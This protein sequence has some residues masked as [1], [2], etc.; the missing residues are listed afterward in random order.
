M[1]RLPDS[2][3]YYSHSHSR[4]RTHRPSSTPPYTQTQTPDSHRYDTSAHTYGPT[5]DTLSYRETPSS[6]SG[7]T[8]E[9]KGEEEGGY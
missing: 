8:G 1:S 2:Y 4:S 6:A 3:T 5:F 7:E 9:E